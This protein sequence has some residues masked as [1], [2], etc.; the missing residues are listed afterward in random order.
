MNKVSPNV[1]VGS[2][3]IGLVL[4]ALF[5]F[6]KVYGGSVANLKRFFKTVL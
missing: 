4:M 6:V 2:S 1:T 3:L 5:A